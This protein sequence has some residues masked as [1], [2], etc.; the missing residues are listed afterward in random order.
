MTTSADTEVLVCAGEFFTDFIFFDLDLLPRLGHETKTDNF[1]SSLGGGAAITA[2]AASLLGR[3][4][5]LVT[6]WGD[7][8]L[9]AEARKQLD[10][11]GVSWCG[12]RIRPDERSGLSVAVST[13]EDRYFLT[14]AGVNHAV[15]EHLLSAEMLERASL[16]GHAHFALTPSRWEAFRS[17]IKQIKKNGTTVSWDLGWDLEAG[18]CQ[19]FQDLCLEL[20]LLFLNEM[21]ACNYSGAR[22]AQGAL[23][24]FQ[25]P[26]NTVVIKQ[27]AAGAIASRSGNAPVHVEGIDVAAL[28]STGAGDAFDGGFLHAWMARRDL[29][30]ALRWGNICGGLS[31]RSPGGVQALPDRKEFD[32]Q[33]AR[34]ASERSAGRRLG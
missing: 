31:T 10:K 7:S 8:S 26:G 19:G 3:N 25:H 4:T 23:E 14:H 17:A 15:E 18:R 29:E 34:L 2:V 11:A 12:S 5:E 1:A 6:V 33:L 16:A 24:Y 13:R 9:E 21:E 30:E 20:D 32:Q 28:E 27:G 22:S